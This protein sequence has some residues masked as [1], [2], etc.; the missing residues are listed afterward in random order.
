MKITAIKI[1]VPFGDE[2]CGLGFEVWG[3]G[4]GVWGFSLDLSSQDLQ[5]FFYRILCGWRKPSA[6]SP[7]NRVSLV[8]RKLRFI[9]TNR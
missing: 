9:W 7:N 2:V 5:K 8:D 1:T 3:S 6:L 4:F